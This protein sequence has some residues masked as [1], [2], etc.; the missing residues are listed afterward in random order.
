MLPNRQILYSNV[1][2][3]AFNC[4]CTGI[5]DLNPCTVGLLAGLQGYNL[6]VYCNAQSA[7]QRVS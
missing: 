2:P 6:V 7:G 1:V 5:R 3:L 4:Y